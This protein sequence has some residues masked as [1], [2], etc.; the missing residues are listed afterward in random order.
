MH[1]IDEL[2]I[3]QE[4]AKDQKLI[5]YL[6]EHYRDAIIPP[7]PVSSTERVTWVRGLN[8]VQTAKLS[9]ARELLGKYPPDVR[10]RLEAIQ[11]Q[12]NTQPSPQEL[13]L[14]AKMVGMVFDS[15]PTSK[16]QL[17][18][19]LNMTAKIGMMQQQLAFRA[20]IFYSADLQGSD[21][22]ALEEWSNTMLL[23]SIVTNMPFLR[24]ETDA[25]SALMALY[26]IRPIEEGFRLDN[27]DALVADLASRLS[28]FPKR[29]L[30]TVDPT[31]QLFVIS[32]W[33]IPEGV[34]S[35]T[36]T[37]DAYERL[38]REVRDEIDMADPKE[39]RRLLR[40]RSRRNGNQNRPV[41]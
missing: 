29:L 4:L 33:M 27:Q 18:P 39:F 38:R 9:S 5:G 25:K 17:L 32:S 22:E 11:T 7:V 20:A 24:R 26:S 15:L 12:I 31:D 1:D 6:Q 2:Q 13:N 8:T 19:E 21:S 10:Q 23:P 37:L 40:D 30:E 28:E 16:R 41:R 34:N 35:N 14:T 36:R 3:L